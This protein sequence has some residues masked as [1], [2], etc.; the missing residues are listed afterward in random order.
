MRRLSFRAP[1][2][3]GV[4]RHVLWKA[5]FKRRLQ[6]GPN[7]EGCR[8]KSDQMNYKVSAPNDHKP[9]SLQ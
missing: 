8:K 3:A 1:P 6:R 5:A 4:T 2:A 7:E 9:L